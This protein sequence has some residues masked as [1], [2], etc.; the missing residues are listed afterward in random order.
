MAQL[1]NLDGA[2]HLID[3]VIADIEKPDRQERHYYAESLRIRGWLLVRKGDPAG[4]ERSYNA[5]L[6]WART[7]RA[8]ACCESKGGLA[9]LAICW[10]RS[11]AGSPKASRRRT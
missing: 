8:H 3:A 7:Q 4:A 6:D 2:L 10:H 1:G 9:R 5:S 11:T